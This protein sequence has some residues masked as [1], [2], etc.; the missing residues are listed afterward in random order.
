M[1]YLK[2]RIQYLAEAVLSSVEDYLINKKKCYKKGSKWNCDKN[3][4]MGSNVNRE[5]VVMKGELVVD[6]GVIKG[7]FSMSSNNQNG[8][9]P[10]TSCKGFPSEVHGK[11][12]VGY[13]ALT[14]LKGFTKIIHGDIILNDNKLTSLVGL[15][16]DIKGKLRIDGNPIENLKGLPVDCPEVIFLSG[17]K[18]KNLKDLPKKVKETSIYDCR[19][20]ET[21]T[22]IIGRD[23]KIGP[24]SATNK[25]TKI[26]E[27]EVKAYSPGILKDQ[28]FSRLVMILL[29]NKIE[30]KSY[31]YWPKGFIT[32]NLAKSATKIQDF[33]I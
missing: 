19:K 5:E 28:F 8:I 24:F 31:K 21:I 26:V 20:I 4:L 17:T 33:G 16:K 11:L 15:P 27:Y 12:T 13:N 1:K 23:L 25:L 3:L 6:F 2:E 22:D 32:K 9:R 10:L 30:L 14:N 29:E 7:N 18:I